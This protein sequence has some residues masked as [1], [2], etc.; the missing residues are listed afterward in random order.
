MMD[1]FSLIAVQPFGGGLSDVASGVV[2]T[3]GNEKLFADPYAMFLPIHVEF[4]FAFDQHHEFI[5]VVD[6]VVPHLPRRIDP[7][8][9]R[10]TPRC[11]TVA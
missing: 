9:A 10:E 3:C 11:P 6:E 5:G 2:G 7:K 4:F 1:L 8:I